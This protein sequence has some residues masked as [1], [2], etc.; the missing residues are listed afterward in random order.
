MKLQ[1]NLTGIEFSIGT[2]FL[3]EKDLGVPLD[4]VLYEIEITEDIQKKI[5]YYGLKRK[6]DYKELSEQYDNLLPNEKLQVDL[7]CNGRLLDS[8][9][10]G[11]QTEESEQEQSTE[12]KLF[13]DYMTELMFFVRGVL[14]MS[15]QEFMNSTPIEIFSILDQHKL[16][17]EQLY[18]L[19][20][21]AHVN[22]IGLTS[23]KKFKEINPFGKENKPFKKV[24]I[25]KKKS[26]LEFLNK[27]G[28]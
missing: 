3:L 28:D 27:V 23:S 19:N 21:I 15:K 22:A 18:G 5:L 20:K 25:D 4:S 26:D 7:K 10:A 24:N 6:I 16:H 17:M 14:H 13:T 12:V 8:F 9:G 1:D 11:K 2:L